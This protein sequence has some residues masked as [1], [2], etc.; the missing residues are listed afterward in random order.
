MPLKSCRKPHPHDGFVRASNSAESMELEESDSVGVFDFGRGIE[1]WK[2]IRKRFPIRKIET[3]LCVVEQAGIEPRF[4]HATIHP[5]SEEHQLFAPI[6]EAI[7]PI[8]ADFL[9]LRVALGP[10]VGVE[11]R[12]PVTLD[13]ISTASSRMRPRIVV[14]RPCREPKETF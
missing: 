5:D 9:A 8:R 14:A 2:G 10:V 13:F 6:A 11:R 12:P 1:R 3:D 4:D 7:V